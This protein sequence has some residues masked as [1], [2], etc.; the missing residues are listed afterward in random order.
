METIVK[1]YFFYFII[2]YDANPSYYISTLEEELWPLNNCVRGRVKLAYSIQQH[3]EKSKLVVYCSQLFIILFMS[4]CLYLC[5]HMHWRHSNLM[6]GKIQHH[7]NFFLCI[8]LDN[9]KI[10]QHFQFSR[11]LHNFGIFPN[12]YWKV[13]WC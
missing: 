11:F 10:W 1:L 8:M 4:I 7:V 6:I 2:E 12:A 9:V 13:S 3:K 5:T